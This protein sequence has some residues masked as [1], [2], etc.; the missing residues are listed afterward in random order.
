[1]GEPTKVAREELEY[2]FASKSS[3]WGHLQNLS[4]TLPTSNFDVSS[5]LDH[6]AAAATWFEIRYIRDEGVFG[7]GGG[8]GVVGGGLLQW[9]VLWPPSAWHGGKDFPH[10]SHLCDCFWPSG[11]VEDGSIPFLYSMALMVVGLVVMA[12]AAEGLNSWFEIRYIR[13]DGVFEGGGGGG[14]VGG[15]LLRW[16]VLWPPSA[17]HDGKDFPHTSHLCNCFWLSG[18]VGQIQFAVPLSRDELYHNSKASIGV[19]FQTQMVEI[20]G[21]EVKAQVWDTAG[22]ER[23]RAVT[24][25]YYRGAVGALVVY[26]ISRRTT[27]ENVKRWLDELN[28]HCDTTV[29]RMLVGNK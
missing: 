29:A 25:A 7:G 18:V 22:Q 14:V 15:C 20:D 27:F 26:D 1:M 21:K 3:R 10:T 12:V 28:T 2:Q 5:P 17:W 16:L 13:D 8:G 23:F 24:F 19:E 9:L 11:V 4:F 6:S